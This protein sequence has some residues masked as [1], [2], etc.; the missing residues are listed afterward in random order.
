MTSMSAFIL[1]TDDP[2]TSYL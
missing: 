1:M 2:P